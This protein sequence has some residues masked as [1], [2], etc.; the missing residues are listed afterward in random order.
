MT[1]INI[2]EFA[3]TLH[4]T[5]PEVITLETM[6]VQSYNAEAHVLTTCPH[7]TR[8]QDITHVTVEIYQLW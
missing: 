3:W 4:V 5:S 8:M 2:Q 7:I 6:Y 1:A